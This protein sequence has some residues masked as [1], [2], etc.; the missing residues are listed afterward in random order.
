MARVQIGEVV[1]AA[2]FAGVLVAAVS[3]VVRLVARGRGTAPVVGAAVLDGALAASI[4]AVLVATLTPIELLGTH[5][6]RPSEVNLRPLEAMRGAP[7]FYAV[8]NAALLVPTIVLLAQRWRRAGI[9]RLT[10]TGAAIS[11]AIEVTQLVHPTRGS[12]VDDLALN[13][14]GAFVA[15]VVGVLVRAAGRRGRRGGSPPASRGPSRPVSA[16]GRPR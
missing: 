1:L 10:L 15:A 12:N 13:T 6:D 11:L 7:R 16:A 5:L 9:V 2:V 8:I 3:G 14:A 4:A